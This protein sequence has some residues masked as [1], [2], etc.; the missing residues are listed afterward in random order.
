MPPLT[1]E[2]LDS[3]QTYEQVADRLAIS[4]RTVARLVAKG[5]IGVV[6]IGAGK[7]HPRIPERAIVDYINRRYSKST[8]KPP[9]GDH[10]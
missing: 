3:L 6:H 8:P 2:D 10:R 1:L 9:K 7:G 4:P 5:E